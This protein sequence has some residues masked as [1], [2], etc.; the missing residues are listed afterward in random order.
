[1]TTRKYH[2]PGDE[3]LAEGL[4]HVD[5]NLKPLAQETPDMTIRVGSGVAI[6]LGSVVKFAGD[7]IGTITAPVTH[8]RIDLVTL[9]SSGTLAVTTGVEGASP[10]VPDYPT[11]KFVVAELYIPVGATSIKNE[12]DGSNGYIL[13]DVRAGGNSDTSYGDGS[14]GVL[15]VVSGTTTLSTDKL[16]KYKSILVDNGATLTVGGA[17]ANKILAALV[18]GDI[19]INGILDLTGMG[20]PGGGA[21]SASPGEAGTSNNAFCNTGAGGGGGEGKI[22]DGATGANGTAASGTTPGSGGTGTTGPDGGQGGSGLSPVAGLGLMS[23]SELLKLGIKPVAL[24]PGGGGGGGIVMSGHNSGGA[25]GGKGGGAL[26]FRCG[27][28]FV[29]GATGQIKLKAEAG[30]NGGNNGFSNGNQGSGGGGG[31]G[32]SL[33]EHHGD[34]TE[35]GTIDVSGAAGGTLV[36]GSGAPAGNGAAG[37]DGSWNHAKV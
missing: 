6:V 11:T 33:V 7:D 31:G 18:Q 32:S 35:S 25:D 22:N 13:R 12:D 36:G 34:Y 20:L 30:Q 29:L 8:P 19:T 37:S 15:H 26:Y 2:A 17:A 28:N 5:D 4:N 1:M 3:I 27:G 23:P 16:W 10:D 14:D 9:D 24:G 21:P